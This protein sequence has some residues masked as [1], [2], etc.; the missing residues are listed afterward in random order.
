MPLY[1]LLISTPVQ[2]LAEAS[3]IGR[4]NPGAGLLRIAGTIVYRRMRFRGLGI[5]GSC[6]R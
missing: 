6:D 2:S 1:W 3:A 4:S 5:A